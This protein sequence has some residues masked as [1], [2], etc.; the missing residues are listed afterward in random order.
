MGP[1]DHSFASTRPQVATSGHTLILGWNQSTTRLI[2]QLAFLRRVF[3]KQNETLARRLFPWMRVLPSTLVAAAPI[4]VL[5]DLD[6]SEMEEHVKEAFAAR[7]IVG[8]RT[9]VGRDVVKRRA[10]EEGAHW[11]SSVNSCHLQRHACSCCIA[12]ARAPACL[13]L[14]AARLSPLTPRSSA[15]ETQRRRT[16]S[17]ACALTRRTP[18]A[19]K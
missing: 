14:R 15:R 2:C 11:S 7:G 1:L 13:C 6:K 16:T 3:K 17:S 10:T 12:A 5:N 8:G 18:C 4:V 19:S 9:V